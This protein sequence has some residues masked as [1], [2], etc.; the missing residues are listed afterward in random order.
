M[1]FLYFLIVST[2]L[3]SQGLLETKIFSSTESFHGTPFALNPA[4][5]RSD[6][7]QGDA[8]LYRET[9]E[10]IWTDN[11]NVEKADVSGEIQG[12][13]V[14]TNVGSGL[15]IGFSY[16]R[17]TY[18]DTLSRDQRGEV[19]ENWKKQQSMARIAVEL[20]EHLHAGF[21]LKFL[22]V[23]YDLLGSFFINSSERALLKP[24]LFGSG[25]GL[26]MTFDRM[27]LSGAWVPTMK[28]K[29]KVLGEEF[30]VT[31]PGLSEM[32]LSSK[33]QQM[34]GGIGVRRWIYRKDDRVNGTTANNENQTQLNL[35]GLNS[36]MSKVFPMYSR[37]IDVEAWMTPAL[38][39]GVRLAYTDY[40]VHTDLQR[41]FPGEEAVSR[42]FSAFH[43]QAHATIKTKG[44]ELSLMALRDSR[45]WE[46][47][48]NNR[49]LSYKQK[50]QSI[51]F[52][53]RS[54]I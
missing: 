27:V 14:V 11:D 35:M 52:Q 42:K 19:F 43:L 9:S 53:V 21:L 10:H 24:S 51:V 25:G 20:T 4:V 17:L 54:Q 8:I 1:K 13:G 47:E 40:E 50:E 46:G 39:A 23:E 34:M 6:V 38:K 31:E 15:M 26:V 44:A 32:T 36:G 45:K 2:P 33:H 49:P 12:V 29:A 28:G 18:T 16:Q 30:I 48:N 5:D 37:F 7:L 3:Y 22:D 41:T